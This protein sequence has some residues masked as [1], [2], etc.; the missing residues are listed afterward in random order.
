MVQLRN[1]LKRLVSQMTDSWDGDSSHPWMFSKLDIKD[2]F[3]QMAINHN[4]AWNFCYVI[5]SLTPLKSID[6]IE[7]VVPNSLQMGWCKSPHFFCFTTETARDIISQLCEAMALPA[8]AF[9]NIMLQDCDELPDQVQQIQKLLTIIEIFVDDFIAASNHLSK[10]HLRHVSR[11]M[12][13]GIHLIFPPPE[14]TIHFRFDPISEKKTSKRRT[15]M[16]I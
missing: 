14:K 7:L 11:A 6:D 4:E 8:H 16:A 13:H 2:G 9:K 10:D 5:P 3:W 1:C 15:H 12:Q